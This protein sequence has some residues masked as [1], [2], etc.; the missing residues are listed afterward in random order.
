M[1]YLFDHW[2]AVEEYLKPEGPL[3]LLFDFDGTLSPIVRHPTLARLPTKSRDRLGRLARMANTYVGIV[4]GRA[5]KDLQRLVSLPNLLYVGNHGLEVANRGWSFTHPI[6]ESRR[7][8]L[9]RL[10]PK[11]RKALASIRGAWVEDKGLSLSLHY[12][13]VSTQSREKFFR[14]VEECLFPARRQGP[15]RVRKGK[16]VIEVCPDPRWNKGTAIQWLRKVMPKD[17]RVLY[18]G[19]DATDEDAFRVLRRDGITVRVGKQKKSNAA[20]YLHE[21]SQ[22]TELL[23]RLL[24]IPKK[25]KA[26]A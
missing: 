20:Y 15:L 12:R 18:I 23:S 21:Q 26:V 11:L 24:L 7:A 16:C 6:A 5:L 10:I 19:D 4:S 25:E 2:G 22:V 9:R 14:V 1:R 8:L 3:L 13:S 17:A